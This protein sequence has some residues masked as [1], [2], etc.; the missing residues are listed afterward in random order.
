MT[1]GTRLS[2]AISDSVNQ[3][4][5][6]TNEFPHGWGFSEGVKRPVALRL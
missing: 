2:G 4:I 5:D 3:L 6:V 1:A